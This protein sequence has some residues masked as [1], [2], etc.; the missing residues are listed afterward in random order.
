VSIEEIC[1][2]LDKAG[3]STRELPMERKNTQF[4]IAEKK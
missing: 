2:E 1:L 4:L 3:F